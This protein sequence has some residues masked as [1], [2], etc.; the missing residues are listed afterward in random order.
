MRSRTSSATRRLTCLR[1][2]GEASIAGPE[3][4]ASTLIGPLTMVSC[5]SPGR[6][7]APAAMPGRRRQSRPAIPPGAAAPD[8]PDGKPAI[9]PTPCAPGARARRYC[10]SLSAK[11][12]P[13][14]L[15]P[16]RTP[17]A[18]ARAVV[19][20]PSSGGSRRAGCDSHSARVSAAPD[21][22]Q[23]PDS[24]PALVGEPPTAG[25][26]VL[27]RRVERRLVVGLL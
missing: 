21:V 4:D 15:G 19:P 16:V 10:I 9:L 22:R 26:S 24:C 13:I 14:G 3:P 17:L 23:E 18:Y 5:R 1:T 7:S 2:P 27:R 12:K 11:A 6:S 8:E 20:S 25:G